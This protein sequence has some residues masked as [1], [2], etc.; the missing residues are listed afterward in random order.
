MKKGLFLFCCFLYFVTLSAQDK[1]AMAKSDS[2]F[3]KGVELYNL[4]KF[5]E[6]IPFFEM[7]DKIDEAQL[8]SVSVRREYSANWLASCYF[9][10]NDTVTAKQISPD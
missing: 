4:R 9:H 1:A 10:I 5:K 2:L 8:D 3:A 6:A 7:S